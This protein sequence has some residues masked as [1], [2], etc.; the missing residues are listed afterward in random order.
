MDAIYAMHARWLTEVLGPG[1]SLFTPGTAIWT[2]G[3]LDELERAFVAHPDTTP[4]RRYEEKLRDQLAGVSPEAK[5]LMA[6]LHAVHFL[7]I[8]VGA[9]SAA[10]KV[11]ILNAILAWMPAPPDVPADV[12]QAMAP[13]LVHP[14]TW[15]MTRRDTQITWLIR[16]SSAWKELPE[17][18]RQALV[19]DPWALKEFTG[20]VDAPSANS[21]QMAVL[22]L[23][24]PDAFDPIVSADHKHWI[25]TRFADV[26]GTSPDVDRR[27]LSIRA[28][29]TPE[30]GEGFDWY[31]D[32][33][34]RLWWKNGKDWK[35]FL[36]WL[37]HSRANADRPAP[38]TGQLLE[39]GDE[40][41][42]AD[43]IVG[44]RRAWQLAG[45]GTE[46]EDA[47]LSYTH[48]RLLAFLDEL[49]RDS[50]GWDSPLRDRPRRV[51]GNA[52]PGRSD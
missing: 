45:W 51:R 10:T 47:P 19:A 4:G 3:H 12:V 34:V 21:A 31:D 30:Y 48:D 6:E 9:I 42:F 50:G 40:T 39:N 46:P 27:L 11:S 25:T 33:L 8:W 16:F 18:Q 17:P 26:A 14:G 13:G 38:E 36:R 15:V 1:D 5:Q 29:L 23:A 44:I 22:H 43:G 49:V 24:H 52:A 37:E 20:R 35:S 7:M 41:F 28:A 32:W 2:K